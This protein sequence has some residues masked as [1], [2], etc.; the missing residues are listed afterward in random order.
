MEWKS[1]KI[2]EPRATKVSGVVWFPLT[3]KS[4]AQ[5]HH[6]ASESSWELGVKEVSILI[7]KALWFQ[8]WWWKWQC[9][10]CPGIDSCTWSPGISGIDA[11]NFEMRVCAKFEEVGQW[12]SWNLPRKISAGITKLHRSVCSRK[13]FILRR[14]L[15]FSSLAVN[16]FQH[17]WSLLSFS[18]PNQMQ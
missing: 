10:H 3:T 2:T 5:H 12:G 7:H 1:R 17:Y 8:G 9:N 14:G 13:W 15:E 18:L 16:C 11:F 6:L 4:E